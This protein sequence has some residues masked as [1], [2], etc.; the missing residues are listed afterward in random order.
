MW[1]RNVQCQGYVCELTY[2]S[3]IAK[4]NE[5]CL[6]SHSQTTIKNAEMETSRK[7]GMIAFPVS[8]SLW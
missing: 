2:L 7:G 6:L 5:I 4:M 1:H 3:V 8:Q